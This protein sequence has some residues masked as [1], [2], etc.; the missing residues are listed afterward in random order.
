MRDNIPG[1][2][3]SVMLMSGT[4]IG[5]RESR[6]I[7]GEYV[8]TTE[9]ILSAKKFEDSIARGTYPLDIHSPDGK[10]SYL[11]DIPYGDYCTIP[12]GHPSRILL[13]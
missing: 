3:N 1:F 2:E 5:V 9:D 10:G 6:R 4:Q 7:I 12:Y 8:L 13:M 11:K